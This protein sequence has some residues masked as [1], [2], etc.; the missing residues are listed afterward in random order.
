VH[1]THEYQARLD[2]LAETDLVGEQ[3]PHRIHSCRALGDVELMRKQTYAAAQK[4]PW[5]VGLPD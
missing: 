2:R 3:P 4:R 1:Q 5:T